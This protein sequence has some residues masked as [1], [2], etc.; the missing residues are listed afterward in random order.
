M[1]KLKKFLTKFGYALAFQVILYV[2]HFLLAP[3]VV[4]HNN[5]YDIEI[6]IIFFITA[7]VVTFLGQFFVVKNIWCWILSIPI[8]LV[9][10]YAYH[11]EHIYDIGRP[12]GFM[13]VDENLDVFLTAVVAL[14]LELLV[15]IV[16]N[17]IRLSIKIYKRYKSKNS[18]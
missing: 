16:T 18:L 15:C 3:L 7:V 13:Y 5:Y 9:L 10:I 2:I 12:N 14:V 8:Y 17:I 6:K 1:D 4:G 11:P